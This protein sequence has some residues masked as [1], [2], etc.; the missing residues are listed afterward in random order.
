MKP[1]TFSE[2]R[3]SDALQRALRDEKYTR[4]TPVQAQAIPH[5]LAG[6]DLLGSAQTG[7]GK[8]AAFAL[9][10]LHRLDSERRAAVA[11]LPRVLVLSPTR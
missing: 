10:I 7:T 8:T 6:R 11:R 4:P 3:L 1:T 2:L 9:P 5:L